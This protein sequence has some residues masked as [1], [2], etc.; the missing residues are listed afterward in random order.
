[1]CDVGKTYTENVFEY[2]NNIINSV[3]ITCMDIAYCCILQAYR[4]V[5]GTHDAKVLVFER[6]Y[7]KPVQ[8]YDLFANPAKKAKKDDNKD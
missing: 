8:I 4:I 3:N 6:T 5:L 1:M 7:T 2:N